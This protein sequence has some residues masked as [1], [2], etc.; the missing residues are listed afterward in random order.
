[1]Q[2]AH[3]RCLLE[4]RNPARFAFRRAVL[5]QG[6][7][8]A[9]LFLSRNA[10]TLPPPEVLLPL[11]GAELTPAQ[12]AL[13]LSG[14]GAEVVAEG[15]RVCACFGVTKQAVRHAVVTRGLESVADIGACLRAGTN[16]G[17]CVPELWAILR[18]V[19]S[20]VGGLD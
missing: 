2:P 8:L 17:S 5:D 10:E 19:R 15:P 9:C 11:L 16:C 12:R 6:R 7:L 18:D 4:L 14:R 3:G 1:M 20:L 13:L